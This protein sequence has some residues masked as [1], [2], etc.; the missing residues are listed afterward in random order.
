MRYFALSIISFIFGCSFIIVENKFLLFICFI[1]FSL[2]ILMKKDDEQILNKIL[3]LLFFIF[4]IVHSNSFCLDIECLNKKISDYEGKKIK[5]YGKL[6]SFYISERSV[7]IIFES[8]KIKYKNINLKFSKKIKL[9]S[10]F[11]KKDFDFKILSGYGYNFE[12]DGILT[13]IYSPQNPLV[14]SYSENLSNSKIFFKIDNPK[15]IKKETGKNFSISDFA[16]YLKSKIFFYIDKKHSDFVKPVIIGIL[17][18]DK[19]LFTSSHREIFE[20]TGTLHIL[21][22]SGFH[23]SVIILFFLFLFKK[24]KLSPTISFIIL[25]PILLLYMN[26]AGESPSILRAGIMA[27]LSLLSVSLNRDCDIISALCFAVGFMIFMNP[28][29]ILN[30]S[31]LLSGSAICGIIFYIRFINQIILLNFKSPFN[32]IIESIFLSL[33]IES[34]TLPISVLFFCQWTPFSFFSNII[35]TPLASVILIFGFLEPIFNI[36]SPIN[37]FIV[38]LMISSLKFLSLFKFSRIFLCSPSIYFVFLYYAIFFICSYFDFFTKKVKKYF[39]CFPIIFIL[40][41]VSYSLLIPYFFKPPKYMEILFFSIGNADSS[42]IIT[43]N[44]KKILIDCGTSGIRKGIDVGKN[45]IAPYLLKSGIDNIDYV[46]ITHE[47]EDHL[48]GLY[49]LSKRIK[50]KNLFASKFIAGKFVGLEK[51]KPIMAGDIINIS[52]DIKINVL[53]PSSEFFYNDINSKSL[54]LKIVYGQN[55]ILYCADIDFETENKILNSFDVKCDVLKIAH[56]GSITSS[57]DVFL[58]N[59]KAKIAIISCDRGDITHP[60]KC[61]LDRLTKYG[62]KY[63]KT[64]EIGAIRLAVRKKNIRLIQNRE[65]L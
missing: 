13:K 56:H 11:P 22:A 17:F 41:F 45:V 31:F 12:I 7:K 47:H 50:I 28:F 32:K 15:I 24:I 34:V 59:T 49:S 20:K 23:I 21:A 36:L 33:S 42:L 18:G 6:K 3:C 61:V 25:L 63:Y 35:A 38:F 51:A 58:K 65:K 30:C 39:F 10:F 62:I 16:I 37:E 5:V 8:E 55:S 60:S 1:S 2:F 64:D 54:V 40:F 43:P 57:S 14:F 19:S 44:G 9:L 4:G 53:S 26:M 46:F 48:G 29:N 27:L 52:D